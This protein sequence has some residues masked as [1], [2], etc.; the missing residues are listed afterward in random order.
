MSLDLFINIQNSYAHL[1]E[2][3]NNHTQRVYSS[4]TNCASGLKSGPGNSETL[5]RLLRNLKFAGTRWWKKPMQP[6]S[7]SSTTAATTAAQPAKGGPCF[8]L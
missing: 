4:S 2:I 1:L 8:S 6:L 5:P 7:N 3:C